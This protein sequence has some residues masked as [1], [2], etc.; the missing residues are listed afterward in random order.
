MSRSYGTVSASHLAKELEQV[1]KE[2]SASIKPLSIT[3]DI[4]IIQLQ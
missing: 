1:F 2:C 3:C 4:S